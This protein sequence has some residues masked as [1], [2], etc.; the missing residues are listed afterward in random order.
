MATLAKTYTFT[1]GT[2]AVA[3]EVNQN[4]DDIVSFVNSN[5]IQKDGSLAMTAALTLPN[6]EPSGANVAVRRRSA[7]RSNLGGHPAGNTFTV[8]AGASGSLVTL[9]SASD[10]FGYTPDYTY[11]MLILLTGTVL[12]SGNSG[13]LNL[14]VTDA[15]DTPINIL[16]PGASNAWA[17]SA[18]N[19]NSYETIAVCAL[20]QNIAAATVPAYKV[21]YSV[22]G[23]TTATVFGFSLCWIN[24]STRQ[25]PN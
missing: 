24:P 21:K 16:G 4:F 20:Q 17:C 7:Y 11:D 13:I 23:L 10:M 9:T 6:A 2:T 8:N 3:A 25:L 18:G 1:T 14:S 15:A 19:N 5:A 12:L 22:T